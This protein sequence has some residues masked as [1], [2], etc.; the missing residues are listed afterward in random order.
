MARHRMDQEGDNRGEHHPRTAVLVIAG[1]GDMPSGSAS[2]ALTNGLLGHGGG[3][4]HHAVAVQEE[5][6]ATRSWCGEEPEPSQTV[7]RHTLHDQDGRPVADVYE[8]WWADLSRFRG[9]T[10]SALLATIGMLQQATTIGRAA[11]RGGGPI[12]ADPADHHETGRAGTP[13]AFAVAAGLLGVIE[14]IVAVPVVSIVAIHLALIAAAD[15]AMTITGEPR[16]HDVVGLAV[17]AFLLAAALFVAM[18]WYARRRAGVALVAIPLF[19]GAVAL[20]AWRTTAHHNLPD[21]GILD[22]ILLL[23]I[24]PLRAAWMVVAALAI[25]ATAA[26]AVGGVLHRKDHPGRRISTAALSMFGPFGLAMV[27]ALVYAAAGT[28]VQKLASAHH[29]Q[30]IPPSKTAEIPWCLSSLTSW[31]PGTCPSPTPPA[32]YNAYDWGVGVFQTGVV[33][34]IY[35]AGLAAVM[36]VLTALFTAGKAIHAR[37]TAGTVINRTSFARRF[38][39]YAPGAVAIVLAPA[40]AM[41]LLTYVPGGENALVWQRNSGLGPIASPSAVLAAAAGWVIG[42]LLAAAR[43]LKLGTGTLRNKGTIGDGVRVPLDLAY[44]IATFLRQPPPAPKSARLARLVRARQSMP[45][46]RIIGRIAALLAHIDGLRPYDRCVI[47][48]HSQGT[49]L[50]TALLASPQGRL[51]IPGGHVHL[52]T[53][54]SPLR[55]LYAERLPDQFRWVDDL[56]DD[57]DAFVRS[58]DGLWIN[59][60]AD[61]DLVG[62]LVFSHEPDGSLDEGPF[63]ERFVARHVDWIVGRGGHGSYWTSPF[64]MEQIAGLLAERP[65]GAVDGTAEQHVSSWRRWMRAALSGTV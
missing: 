36:L 14:W 24:Y 46:Q 52:I 58:L 54:G 50:A 17:V 64:V 8:A 22:A 12:S 10:R 56:L 45:R 15:Y 13:R 29:F 26:L 16:R 62:R 5:Y 49:V 31:Q 19:A 11:L 39:H 38:F 53:M 41:V 18:R 37:A 21:A 42:G 40:A 65:S 2:Q 3:R 35:V 59:F 6:A 47:V 60:G 55:H 20:A 44:D 23:A 1:V 4:F 28:A 32:V 43:A 25:L 27:G 51:R 33:P 9:A 48:S 63:G 7:T 57:P 34:M 61:D 30:V